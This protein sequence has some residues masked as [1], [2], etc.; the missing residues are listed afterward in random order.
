MFSNWMSALA[1]FI[2]LGDAGSAMVL[3]VSSN[4]KTRWLAASA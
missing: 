4:S 1:A 3:G 2:G